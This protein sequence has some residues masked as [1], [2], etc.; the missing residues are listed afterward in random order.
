MTNSRSG[1]RSDVTDRTVHSVAGVRFSRAL[2]SPVVE[3]AE[4]HNDMEVQ[5]QAITWRIPA[6]EGY[7]AGFV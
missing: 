2:P 7:T 1:D 3:T 6:L 5:C 4:E